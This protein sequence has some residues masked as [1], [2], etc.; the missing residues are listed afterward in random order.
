V[1]DDDSRN[2]RC[3]KSALSVIVVDAAK[4]AL[5]TGRCHP[6]GALREPVAVGIGAADLVISIGKNDKLQTR[7]GRDWSEASTVPRG[8]A[9][10]IARAPDWDAL[11]RAT[12]SWLSG[13]GY[14]GGISRHPAAISG[15]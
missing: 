15:G 4:A 8:A 10:T 6:R 13:F 14:P 2:R 11:E 3:P 1:L 9:G 5:A 7:F 12:R